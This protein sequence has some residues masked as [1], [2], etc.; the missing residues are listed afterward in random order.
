MKKLITLIAIGMV[1]ILVKAAPALRMPMTV[2]QPDGTTLT[3]EQFGDEHH[4]WT[5]TTDGTMV[6]NTGHGYYVALI[7]DQGELEATDMLAHEAHQRNSREQELIASQTSR[8]EL[9]HEKGQQ[10]LRRAM[11]IGSTLRYLPHQGNVRILCILAQYQDVQFT[12]NN[13]VTAF[14]QLMNGDTQADL[15]NM[16]QYN[17]AS[18]RQYFK[19][20]SHDQFSPQFDVVGPVTLPKNMKDYGG[21]KSDGSDDRFKDFCSDA[22][23]KV[24][25]ENLVTDWSIYDNNGDK[26]VELVCIIFAGYGQNQGGDNSTLWAKASNQNIKINDEYKAAFFNCSSELFNPTGKYSTYINGTGVFI[27]EMS[28]CMGLPDLYATTSSGYVNN[29]G[30]ESWDIM[31]YGL[32]NNNGWAPCLYTAWEQEVMGWTTIEAITGNGLLSNITPLEEG[33]KS[34]KIAN[35]DND[36]EYIVL[37]N[38]QQ[39]GLNQHARGHGLLVYH[40]AYPY[41]TVN[42]VDTPNNTPGKPAVAVVPAGGMLI[43]KSLQKTNNKPNNPYTA[44]EWKASMEASTF[45]GANNVTT[46]NDGMGLPNYYFYGGSASAP[47]LANRAAVS[48]KSV[49]FSLNNITE[50]ESGISL[51]VDTPTGIE[52]IELSGDGTMERQSNGE[53]EPVFNLAGQRVTHPT[54]GLYI[55]N[56]RKYL[57]K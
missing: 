31:D 17:V 23:A 38:I 57:L 19:A 52:E 51:L 54:K 42:M 11:N 29:Q 49:G 40:V 10:A 7:N 4:H 12:V 15:G 6:I 37:E 26:Y 21:T 30:M 3:V 32:Y 20:S 45:P 33:G 53:T 16:N 25:E 55:R 13:P 34:Y 27:H 22:M 35:P 5:A 24:K 28:H 39:R 18:V 46:L 41:T 44:A 14:E 50:S 47:S 36:R 2:T 1:A 8:R 43:Y 9:F 48:T 56:G